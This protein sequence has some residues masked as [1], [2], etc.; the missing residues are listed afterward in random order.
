MTRA[1]STL[2]SETVVNRA[3]GALS[4]VVTDEGGQPLAR[5]TVHVRGAGRLSN[6]RTA[7]TDESGKF[8][9]ADLPSGSYVATASMMGYV[10]PNA[11][12]WDSNATPRYYRP[13]ENISLTL[14][15]GGV[16]TGK[17]LDQ[18]GEPAVAV[19]VTAARVRDAAGHTSS[20]GN[21]WTPTM[22]TDDRGIY[23]IYGLMPGAYVVYVG[24]GAINFNIPS[25]FE[26]D[27]PTYYPS[28]TARAAATEV[29][30]R[31]GEEASG[32]DVRHRGERGH[33]VGG[34]LSGAVK[35][36]SAFSG[37]NIS[38]SQASDNAFIASTYADAN[39]Q[40]TT[41]A[42]DGVAD[43]NYI[44]SAER[45]DPRD[46]SVGAISAP[47][48]IKVRGADVANLNL[49]LTPLGTISGRIVLSPTSSAASSQAAASPQTS[50]PPSSSPQTDSATASGKQSCDAAR[51]APLMEELAVTARRDETESGKDQWRSR[52]FNT[53]TTVPK[54]D[55]GFVITRVAP[56]AY[57]L[58]V[59]FPNES[60]YLLSLTTSNTTRGEPAKPQKRAAAANTAAQT[61][62]A[63]N[64]ASALTLA[65]GR[66][67]T[68]VTIT[69]AGGA[70]ALKGHVTPAAEGAALPSA[71]TVHLVPADDTAANDLT[72]YAEAE[73][74]DGGAFAFANLSPGKYWLLA[75][76]T[77][78]AHGDVDFSAGQARAWN[79]ESR[80]ALRRAAEGANARVELSPC[81]RMDDFALRYAPVAPASV[82]PPAK[83]A[84]KTE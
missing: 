74:T 78:D 18:K 73:T 16:I 68:N 7:T 66:Q 32:I 1:Q 79:A 53:T 24:G 83:P 76:A 8:E 44:V 80:A 15:K 71:L 13:S 50:S 30:V 33:T 69:L 39:I 49:T 12:W 25:A 62:A 41:F 40:P 82:T 56:A 21:S 65:P 75:E 26:D 51:D 84:A 9:I 58:N 17:I 5:A 61:A 42:F 10:T 64:S 81:Q 20:R 47:Q 19:P 45:A 43:G 29:T 23:R 48:R 55:G 59:L 72:R 34:A 67:I 3:A 14:I 37:V 70:A 54:N 31:S 60:W 63:T 35:S 36:A 2:E 28:V 38:L 11:S 4:G 46:L 6:D 77:A 57:R 52:F 27:V 22:L